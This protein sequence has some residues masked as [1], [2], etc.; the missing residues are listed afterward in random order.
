MARTSIL[1]ALCIILLGFGVPAISIYSSVRYDF[2]SIVAGI[3][4]V[5]ALVVAAA[6]AVVG[7]GLSWELNDMTSNAITPEEKEKLNLMRAD[8]RATLEEL[9]DV[10]AILR[11]I[12]DVLKTAQ[13]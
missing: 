7:M 5:F 10:V 13:E 11:E 9:D 4:A 2:S 1:T 8:Q 12:R 6:L 3:I